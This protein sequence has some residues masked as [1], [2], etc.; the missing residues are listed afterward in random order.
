MNHPHEAFCKQ[1][2]ELSHLYGWFCF[3]VRPGMYA[4]GHYAT[5]VAADGEG[6]PDETFVNELQKRIVWFEAKIP[7]DK[8]KPKQ[9]VWH[10]KI[11]SAGGELY[12]VTPDDWDKI[13]SV[14]SGVK[15]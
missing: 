3:R 4:N 11:R 1:I 5:Q 14:L 10:D 13:V 12:V 6:Y 9:Q 7:P 8:V 15:A 2:E